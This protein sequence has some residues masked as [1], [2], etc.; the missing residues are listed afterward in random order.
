L[1]YATPYDLSSNLHLVLFAMQINEEAGK[2]S[3]QTGVRVVAAYGGA[4]ITQQVCLFTVHLH[5]GFDMVGCIDIA[6][7]VL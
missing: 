3:Y 2:L 7:L 5:R 4:P 1:Q 6:Q